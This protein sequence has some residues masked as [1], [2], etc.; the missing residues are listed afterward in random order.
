MKPL[1]TLKKTPSFWLIFLFQLLFLASCKD[2]NTLEPDPVFLESKTET[3]SLS[4]QEVLA[5]AAALNQSPLLSAYIKNGVKVYKI[6]YKTKNTDGTPITASG[7]IILPETDQ[8]ASMISVQHGTITNP[9]E[10]PS[11]YKDGSEVASFGTLFAS[12]GYII[13]YPDYIGYGVSASLPHPYEH[14]A[15]LASSTLDF[16]RASREFLKTQK[17]VT[18]NEKLLLAG[19]SE[20]GY[21]TMSLQKKIE[22]EAPKEFNLVAASSGA[23]AYDKTAFMKYIINNPTSASPGNNSLYLWVLLTYDR[24][25]ELNQPASYYFKEPYASAIAT[26]GINTVINESFHN[27]ISD[28]FREE[29]NTGQATKFIAAT[30]DNDV[31]NWRPTTPTLLTHGNSDALVFYFNTENAFKS[32]QSLGAPSVKLNTV[33]NGD[34]ASSIESFLINTLIFFTEHAQ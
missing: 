23:G 3:I 32:M 16:I 19:Y 15:S 22:E 2:D 11:F 14:R 27:I 30:A 13:L 5:K 21:A 25:Y 10:A 34:H 8:P 33:N 26:Q 12:M 28:T 24:I 18:W 29:I 20:G 9:S 7:S 6:T 1:D 31:Y 17:T 4:K